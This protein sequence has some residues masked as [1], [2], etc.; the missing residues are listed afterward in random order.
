MTRKAQTT[1]GLLLLIA[2]STGACQQTAERIKGQ[3][4]KANS[5]SEDTPLTPEEQYVLGNAYWN[6]EGLR[7]DPMQAIHWFRKAAMQGHAEAQ[8][9][10]GTA[11]MNGKGV[12]KNY[13]EAYAWITIVK[14][15]GGLTRLETRVIEVG[16]S[17]LESRLLMPTQI[18]QGQQR[19]KELQ[20]EIQ[21]NIAERDQAN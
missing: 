9:L 2:L 11:Y 4:A 10:L 12:Q 5:E 14:A 1:I 13:I 17:E 3:L 19:A 18:T 15:T 20:K 6:G 8:V 7:E 16:I 21:A